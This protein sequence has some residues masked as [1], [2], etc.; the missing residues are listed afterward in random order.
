[1]LPVF[2]G[3]DDVNQKAGEGL[4]DLINLS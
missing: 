1:L 4:F 3:E 2:S